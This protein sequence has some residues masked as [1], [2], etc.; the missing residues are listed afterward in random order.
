MAVGLPLTAFAISLLLTAILIHLAPR[1]GLMDQPDARK[2]HTRPV[3]KGGGL[4]LV[5][6]VTMAA[7]A[8]PRFSQTDAVLLGLGLLIALLG[9]LDD[10]FNFS[11]QLRLGVQF[12]VAASAVHWIEMNWV[13]GVLAMFW[14]VAF[15]NAFNMLDNMDALS[16]GVAWIAAGMFAVI[17]GDHSAMPYLI[18]MGALAGFLWFN[19]PPARIFM[20]D[21][22]STFLGFFFGVRTLSDGIIRIDTPKTWLVPLCV[23]AV[24]LY[25]Q[26]TVVVLRLWQG[27]SPFHADKQHLS[28]RL[29]A[30]GL[31]Q[32]AAVGVILLFGIVSGAAG[33]AIM[34]LD[35]T[36]A[37]IVFGG[38]VFG[39]LV[40]AL[41]EYF[42]HY[43]K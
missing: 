36:M 25:D 22:G 13:V 15:V 1:L 18:L 21:A 34:R 11:W 39:W 30:L 43:R 29:V 4:A 41:V 6:A 31:S 16:A 42:P 27:K 24:P 7:L 33:I 12:L 8:N 35:E 14:I 17:P 32:P 28:H 9:L 19:R 26:V 10:L 38:F 5:A 20:G 3:P 40:V 23:L 37:W 2:V